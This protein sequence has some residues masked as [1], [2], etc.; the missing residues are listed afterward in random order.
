MVSKKILS[1]IESKQ[2]GVIVDLGGGNNSHPE[3]INLDILDL[4]GVD[5]VQDLEEFPW[6]LPDDCANL[7]IASHLVEHINPA[8][9]IFIKFMNEVWRILKPGGK[10]MIACPY[11]S[12]SG[13]IQDPTHCNPCNEVTWAYFDPLEPNTD[14]LLWRIYKPKPWRIECNVW[15][16]TANME[17]VLIKRNLNKKYEK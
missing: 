2:Q 14:G 4:P 5:I 17:V 1:L 8:K 11:G 10:M 16:T 7:V 3:A 9:G 12:S 6:P 13:Q 15:D